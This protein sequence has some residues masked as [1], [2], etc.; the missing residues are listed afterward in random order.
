MT[1][2]N[3]PLVSICCITYNHEPYI[4]DAIEGFL[5]QKT[6]FPFE[7]VIGEDCSTDGTREIV[8]DYAKKYPNIIRVIT[9]EKNVG[10]IN[11]LNRTLNACKGKYT[12]FCEGDDYWIDPLKLQKQVDIMNGDSTIGLIYT[13]INIRN[14]KFNTW[15]KSVYKNEYL[16]RSRNFEEHLINKGYLAPLTWLFRSELIP[17][18]F[19]TD[20]SVD[21]SFEAILNA[22]KITKVYYLNEVT[23]VKNSNVTNSATNQKSLVDQFEYKKGVFNIQKKYISKYGVQENIKDYVFSSNYFSL[24]TTALRIND[25]EFID[26]ARDYFISHNLSYKDFEMLCKNNIIIEKIRE[27]KLYR[28]INS[29]K[30]IRKGD[31]SFSIRRK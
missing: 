24:L 22:F 13:D 4:R 14:S 18:L 19:S 8:F 29:F 5:M 30:K 12:A 9:S 20:S 15:Y 26:E 6:N 21:G 1:V 10:M 11:N 28:I 17:F 2:M 16:K 3:E 27:S 7:M 31:I 23:G 25:H